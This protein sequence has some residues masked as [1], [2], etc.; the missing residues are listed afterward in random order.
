LFASELNIRSAVVTLE[1]S[2]ILF[3]SEWNY[4]SADILKGVFVSLFKLRYFVSSVADLH[5]SLLLYMLERSNISVLNL[6]HNISLV[7]VHCLYTCID[8][9]F[10]VL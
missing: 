4:K 7:E 1:L 10:R 9:C 6:S 5:L 3:A 2:S 8:L